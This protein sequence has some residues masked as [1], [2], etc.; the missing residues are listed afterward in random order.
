MVSIAVGAVVER[1]VLVLL[2]ED[3]GHAVA[4]VR[5]VVP[6][7]VWQCERR[8]VDEA[9]EDALVEVEV[10]A[11]PREEEERVVHLWRYQNRNIRQIKFRTR[12][13]AIDCNIRIRRKAWK[14][15]RWA[16]VVILAFVE[17]L[18]NNTFELEHE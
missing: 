12:R 4:A 6:V 11:V 14:T 2:V 10:P 17:K 5:L 7:P 1:G 9:A 16:Q 18:L 8:V 13:L 3:L 15:R